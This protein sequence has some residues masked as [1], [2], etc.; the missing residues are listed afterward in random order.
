[1]IFAIIIFLIQ[2]Y[3]ALMGIMIGCAIV[4]GFFQLIADIFGDEEDDS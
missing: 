1:M 3:L 4:G 2:A